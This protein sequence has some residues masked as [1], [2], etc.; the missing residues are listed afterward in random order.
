MPVYD[1]ATISRRQTS[2]KK[3]NKLTARL[4]KDLKKRGGVIR[5]VHHYGHRPLAYPIRRKGQKHDVG[6]YTRYF[7]Q[8]SPH[9]LKEFLTT[10]RLDEDVIRYKPFKMTPLELLDLYTRPPFTHQPK[11]SESHYDALKRTTNINYYIARTLLIQGK[12][13]EDEIKALGTVP[14]QFEPYFRSREQDLAERVFEFRTAQE[15]DL[16][17]SSFEESEDGRQDGR[18]RMFDDI[19]DFTD[20]TDFTHDG[21]A[22]SEGSQAPKHKKSY[23]VLDS[24]EFDYLEFSNEG[25]EDQEQVQK[26]AV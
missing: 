18:L 13:N 16:E 26:D 23:Q 21:E 17:D 7:I 25:S 19:D 22:V 15:Q 6:R 11:I 24:P 8:A 12:M 4:A 10:L 3:M 14:I 2:N 20:L 1:V 9:G 5:K